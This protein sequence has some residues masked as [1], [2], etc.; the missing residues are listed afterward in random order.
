MQK[1][2][3]RCEVFAVHVAAVCSCSSSCCCC[4]AVQNARVTRRWA[5]GNGGYGRLGH[6]VQQDEFSPRQVETLK[7]RMPAD[8]SGVVRP[9]LEALS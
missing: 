8:P 1:P 9:S 2:L 3:R 4:A 7:G 5:A 6:S